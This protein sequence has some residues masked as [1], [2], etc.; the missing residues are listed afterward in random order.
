VLHF[1]ALAGLSSL[2]DLALPAASQGKEVAEVCSVISAKH[3]LLSRH[4]H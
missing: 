3:V 2:R 1:D 4:L